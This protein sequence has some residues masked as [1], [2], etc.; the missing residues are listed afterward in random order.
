MA[1]TKLYGGYDIPSKATNLIFS[2]GLLD[3]W[4]GGGF[5][6]SD[7]DHPSNVFCVMPNG[8]HHGDL[9]G[10]EPDDPDD[11][12]RCRALEEATIAGWLT[13]K[14]RVDFLQ[15]AYGTPNDGCPT[16]EKCVAGECR[17][18]VPAAE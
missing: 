5:Y 14:T 9:R 15:C 6:P 2:N 16:G 10:P 4:H 17:P 11:I 18:D 7:G 8:A 13:Q 3:P 12:K 1:L